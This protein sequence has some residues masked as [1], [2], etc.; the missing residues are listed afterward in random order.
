METLI[1][2]AWREYPISA[3][4][5]LGIGL[6]L[7]GLRMELNCLRGA[8]RGDSGKFLPW[9]R[10]SGSRSLAWRWPV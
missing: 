2:L 8:L 3:L 1:Q 5:A 9:I 6:A 7:W 4:I 10:A